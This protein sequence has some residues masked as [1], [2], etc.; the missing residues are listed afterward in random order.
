MGGK[1]E[2]RDRKL[3]LQGNMYRKGMVA[4]GRNRKGSFCQFIYFE[5][6][7]MSTFNY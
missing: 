7:N 4:G 6:G 1:K 3:K 5:V 2:N